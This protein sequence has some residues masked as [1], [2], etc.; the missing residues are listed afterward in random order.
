MQAPDRQ[1]MP[2][3]W[4][5]R[6]ENGS[7]VTVN[8]PSLTWIHHREAASYDVQWA[9]RRNMSNAVTVERHRWCVYTHHEPLKPGKYYWRFRVRTHNGEVSAWSQIREFTVNSR[10]VL[11]PKPTLAQMKERVGTAHPRL[12]VRA[13]DLPTL[14]AVSYTHLTLPTTPYV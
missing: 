10:A 5:Y 13:K 11:F 6:P 8:P 4:G 2:G 1:P 3:E 7:I 14:R 9:T 12:F